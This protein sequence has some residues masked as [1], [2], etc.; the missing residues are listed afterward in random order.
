MPI[1]HNDEQKMFKVYL[2]KILTENTFIFKFHESYTISE[3]IAEIKR[4]VLENINIF[5]INNFN[6]IEVIEILGLENG[7]YAPEMDPSSTT[8]AE[9]YQHIKFKY[10]SFYIREKTS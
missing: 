5:S 1:L 10:I 2:K 7:E 9:Y 6:K 8:L 4:V 3:L